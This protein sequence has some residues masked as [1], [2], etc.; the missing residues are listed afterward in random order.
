[1]LTIPENAVP[2]PS[3]PGP[4]SLTSDWVL[5]HQLALTSISCA[6]REAPGT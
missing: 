6:N 2:S 4:A 5:W 1:M 3:F